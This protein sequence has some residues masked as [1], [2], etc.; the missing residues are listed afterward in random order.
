MKFNM[1]ENQDPQTLLDLLK[2]KA[3]EIKQIKKKLK[4]CEDKYVEVFK[5]N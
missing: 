4:T 1:E 2:D 3:K 5:A